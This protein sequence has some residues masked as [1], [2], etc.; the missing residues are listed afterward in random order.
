MLTVGKTFS[1]GES[2][3]GI[4]AEVMVPKGTHYFGIYGQDK[5]LNKM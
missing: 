2:N 4:K 5:I 3:S 1:T